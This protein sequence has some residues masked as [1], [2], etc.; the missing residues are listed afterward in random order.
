MDDDLDL[1]EELALW[2]ERD[3]LLSRLL[4]CK[5]FKDAAVVLAELANA[6]GRSVGRTAGPED[7]LPR[8]RAR[9]ARRRRPRRSAGR[10]PPGVGARPVPPSTS[11]TWRPS[12]CR[13]TTR[14]SS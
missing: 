5:M 13:S 3:L 7:E 10:V 4:E 2:E 8:P 6:A 1:D 12:G 11:T 9:P 14:S